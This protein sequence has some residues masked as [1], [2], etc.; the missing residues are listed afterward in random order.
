MLKKI[1]VPLDGSKLAER[2]LP[3]AE[4]FA[5]KYEGELIFIWVLSQPQVMPVAH[6]GF[7]VIT[8]ET[9]LVE[10]EE[11]ANEYLGK[12]KVRYEEKNIPTTA[13]V[14]QNQDIA[15]AIIDYANQENVDV[16]VKTTHGRTGLSRWLFG[17]VALKVLQGASCPVFLVR[18]NEEDM[19]D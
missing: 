14:L 4:D 9:M 2:A 7:D 19:N 12:L 17:N 6:G 10:S 15:T 1:L 11:T 13:L 3:Y 18:I 5:Q 8:L 16:I